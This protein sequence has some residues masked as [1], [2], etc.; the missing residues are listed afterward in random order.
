MPIVMNKQ[1]ISIFCVILL[2]SVSYASSPTDELIAE[3]DGTVPAQT[4]SVSRSG[5]LDVTSSTF[6]SLWQQGS[7]HKDT[8]NIEAPQNYCCRLIKGH[9]RNYIGIMTPSMIVKYISYSANTRLLDV[10]IDFEQQII[11]N[12]DYIYITSWVP[13]GSSLLGG[14][15]AVQVPTQRLVIIKNNKIFRPITMPTSLRELMPNSYA[16]MFY[17][18]PRNVV[19]NA[20]YTIKFVDGFGNIKSYEV[21]NEMIAK[22]IESENNFYSLH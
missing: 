12:N 7:Y 4:Q 3:L 19:L 20:P 9:D 14:D 1:L 13:M 8:D 18:F 17:G 15:I 22:S 10:P 2:T 11:N 5:F 6:S 16:P 21:T